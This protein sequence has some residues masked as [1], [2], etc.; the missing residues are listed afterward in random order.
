M[1]VKATGVCRNDVGLYEVLGSLAR[2]DMVVIESSA[3]LRASVD[4]L[5]PYN[6][7]GCRGYS[8]ALDDCIMGPC[9]INDVP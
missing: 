8:R 1:M 9:S 3:L 5:C 6:V 7:A 2:M 4:R